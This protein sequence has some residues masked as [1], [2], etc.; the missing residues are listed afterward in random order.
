MRKIFIP[1]LI[2]VVGL[3]L[4]ITANEKTTKQANEKRETKRQTTTNASRQTSQQTMPKDGVFTLIELPYATDALAP[5]I[6]QQTI[7]LH[8]GKHLRGYVDK[9]NSLLKGSNYKGAS[10]E[11]IVATA[12]GA[13]FDN[14][15]QTLNHNLYF[16]QFSPR[17]KKLSDGKLYRAICDKW[18]SEEA[19]RKAFT[20]AGVAIFGSGW[21]WLAANEDG[22]LFIEK[23]A[24][25]SN[26]IAEGLIPLLGFDV[27]EHAYYLDY[28]NRRRDHIDALWLIVDWPTIE[29]RYKEIINK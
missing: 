29:Q 20:D 25:G 27:W 28:Q 8:Y 12:D 22:E 21:V 17:A 13:L 18:G 9:L 10:L 1:L 7:E 4:T 26:P 3:T 5:V 19:F 24:N 11:E 14:A 2:S 16:T 6:S 15:G 23:M